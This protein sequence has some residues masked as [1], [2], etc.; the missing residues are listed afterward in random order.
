MRLYRALLHAYPASFRAEYG[1]ELSRVFVRR[2]EAARNP[3]ALLLLW[4]ETIADTLSTAAAVHFDILT[5]DL[6]YAARTLLRAPGFSLTVI[7][8]AALGIG[9]GA[10]AFTLVDHVLLR[11]LPFAAQDRLTLLFED[12]VSANIHEFD[13]SPANYRDWARAATSFDTI[14]CFRGL[15]VNLV[16]QAEPRRL[17]GASLSASILPMLGVAPLIGR[18]FTPEDDRDGAPGTLILS[19]TLW[20][21]SFASDPS[22]LGRKLL[23]DGKPYTVIGVMPRDFYFPF[24]TALLWTPMRFAPRDF[25]DRTNTYIYGFARLKRGA[26]LEQAQAEMRTIGAQLSRAYPNELAHVG[27]TVELLRDQV[28]NRT[29]MMLEVL[30]A[31]SLCVLLVVCTNLANLLLARA[32]DRRKELAVRAAMGAGRERLVRQMLTESLLLSAVA[33]VA[34]ILVSRA[35]LPLLVRL[36]PTN[37]PISE[38]PSID[39]RV[40]FFAI[41]ATLATGI[42]LGLLPALRIGRDSDANDLREGSRSGVGGRKEGLRSA[43][44]AAEIAGSVVLL[45]CC[46]LLVRA[47]WRVQSVDPGFRPEQVLSLRTSLPM[48]KY[49][50]TA[51]RVRF[52]HQVLGEAQQLPGVTGAA[53]TSFLPMTLRGGLWAVEIEGRPQPIADRQNVSLRYVTPGFFRI[54]S[55]PL[56]QGRDVAESDSRDAPSV[57]IVSQSF[58]RKY[59][60]GGDPIGHRIHMAFSQP[61]IIGVVGD[62]HVRG[63]ERTSEPQVYFSYQQVGDGS[64]PWYTPKDLVV[65]TTGDPAALAPALR[66]IIHEADPEQPISEVQTL[67]GLLETE[68]ASRRTQIAALGAFAGIAF[69]LAAIGIH[70]VLSFAVSSRTQEIGVRMALGATGGAIL[71]MIFRDALSLA[72]LGALAGAFFAYAAGR[73]MESLLFGVQPADAL[74]FASAIALCSLMTLAGSVLP[75]IRAVRVD[76]YTAIRI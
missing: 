9:C 59:W 56:L 12:H 27:V 29:R 68:T 52:Y 30:L 25:E 8:V 61:T 16:G 57:A 17:D 50:A 20:Q 21:N 7:L 45:V 31:A 73:A 42:G 32:L 76:P 3:F 5:Q 40:M 46:G 19:Y 22:V 63:L 43:L 39:P 38:I 35:A 28:S 34:G 49:E 60:P 4:L 24:R 37:L 64:L 51:K 14:G 54:M 15:S 69:L 36:V 58:A 11:P 55:I 75:A 48:P 6:R 33:G 18:T 65:R 53:Y 13:V 2:R 44:V 72:A 67:T 26:A 66:R 62:V 70:G 10:A 47:L 41:L 23:L 1:E 71:R 74:A